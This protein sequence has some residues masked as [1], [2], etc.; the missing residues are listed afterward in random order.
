MKIKDYL[1]IGRENKTFFTRGFVTNENNN[2]ITIH[3]T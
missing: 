3:C 1:L 2:S